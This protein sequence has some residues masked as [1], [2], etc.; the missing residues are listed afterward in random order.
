[1]V[2]RISDLN[3]MRL[4]N[5][6]FNHLLLKAREGFKDLSSEEKARYFVWIA[7]LLRHGDMA[8]FLYEREI[9]DYQRAISSMAPL[10]PALS[11]P[12]FVS[13]WQTLK[14]SDA[15]FT[16][17]YTDFIDKLITERSKA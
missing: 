8:N 1:M 4:T 6:E 3:T 11:E 5:P 7:S 15:S 10:L 2:G 13:I 17:D 14:N 12:G 9:I 16:K